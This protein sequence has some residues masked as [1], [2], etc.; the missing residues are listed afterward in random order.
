MPAYSPHSVPFGCEFALFG[1][2]A[3][4]IAWL[5]ADWRPQ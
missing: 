1:K 5:L 3:Q 2:I 4:F